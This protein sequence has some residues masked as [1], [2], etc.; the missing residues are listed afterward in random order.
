MNRDNKRHYEG[1]KKYYVQKA[2]LYKKEQLAEAKAKARTKATKGAIIQKMTELKVN[3][4][5]VEVE[6]NMKWLTLKEEE[7]IKWEKSETGPSDG[8]DE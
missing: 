5:R 6:G 1:N 4:F 2:K 8:D 3:R 7:T